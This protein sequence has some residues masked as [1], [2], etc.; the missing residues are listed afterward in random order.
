MSVM[1]TDDSGTE[2]PFLG[3]LSDSSIQSTDERRV[4]GSELKSSLLQLDDERRKIE[5][6]IAELNE[7]LNVEI[8]AGLHEPLVDSEDY[9]RND[10]D[11]H[12]ARISRNRV[13]CLQT[14]HSQ[15]MAKI[16][17]KLHQLHSLAKER[18]I[19]NNDDVVM[20][21]SNRAESDPKPFIPPEPLEPFLRV[22]QVIEGS[23]A[24]RGGLRNN[25]LVIRFGTVT[26]L[27]F[28]GNLAT[29]ANIL[30]GFQGQ[31]VGLEV[32]REQFPRPVRLSLIPQVWTGRGLLGCKMVPIST[33]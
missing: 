4:F 17:T 1:D 29:I 7:L 12:L 21:A 16:Q 19:G 24:Y 11:V 32:K 14:D 9:P 30:S 23:P 18:L 3:S 2:E 25:D 6:E 5:A 15:I 20:T 22:E 31:V 13:A 8:G 10:I 27:N 28:N 33:P 26:T